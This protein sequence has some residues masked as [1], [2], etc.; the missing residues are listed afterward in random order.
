MKFSLFSK[1][2][3]LF[4]ITICSS[5]AFSKNPN[6]VV[7][8][9][10]AWKA[11]N[12]PENSIASLKY[13]IYIKCI[14]SEFDVHMTADNVLV[15]NHDPTYHGLTIEK[16]T[17]KEL[18]PFKLS[19]GENIPTLKEYLKTGK[20]ANTRLVCEIKPASSVERG[21]VVAQKV[22]ELVKAMKMEKYVDYI[23]FDYEMLLK[24]RSLDTKAHLQYLNGTKSPTELKADKINGAD[25]HYSVFKRNPDWIAESKKLGLSLNAW[26][27]NDAKD[28][29]W[30]IANDFDFITTNEPELAFERIKNAPI[31]KDW[32]LVWSDEFNYKGL[33]DDKKWGYDV[34]GSGW[35]NNEQQFYTEKDTSTAFVNNGILTISANKTIKENKQYTSA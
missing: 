33:P 1:I 4:F 11:K 5:E 30:L 12:F 6:S 15:V 2:L 17:Y 23:S 18:L 24:I 26:T 35:G 31:Q 13:A 32:K 25:Y 16:V 28:L 9:R 8:H 29:D 7:A 3:L 10:G 27:V 22:V 34:G 21:R 19:N 14:G 20:N